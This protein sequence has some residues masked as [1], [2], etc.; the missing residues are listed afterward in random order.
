[1]SAQAKLMAA[2][3]KKRDDEDVPPPP[4]APIEPT[5]DRDA[6]KLRKSNLLGTV[7]WEAAAEKLELNNKHEFEGLSSTVHKMFGN[8]LS[9]PSE[10]KYRKIKI[11]N[12]NFQAKVYTCKGAPELFKMAGF[13]EVT[14]DGVAF[15]VL[16]EDS[17]LVQ[18]QKGLDCLVAQAASRSESEEK[19]RKLDLEKAAKAR[20]ERAKKA[21]AEANPAAYDAAVAQ[22]ASSG[23]MVDEDEAM[24]DAISEWMANHPEIEAG[25]AFD[26]YD[27][28]R[29]VPGP[30]GVVVASVVASAG[31]KYFDLVAHMKRSG[32]GTWS[33]SKVAEGK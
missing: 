14:E 27:I 32:S 26:A 29:Q 15:L 33:V 20:E 31:V 1:M 3:K 25:R 11:M 2:L 12:P 8:V 22:C 30:G 18:L 6:L 4:L 7:T 5:A 17:D 9:N 24:V 28:E 23:A 16:P 21:Q 10:P 13:K 19:K